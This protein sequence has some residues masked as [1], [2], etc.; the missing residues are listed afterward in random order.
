MEPTTVL[1]LLVGVGRSGSVRSAVDRSGGR[2]GEPCTLPR[3]RDR[4]VPQAPLTALAVTRL[5]TRP[6]VV[7]G[8]PACPIGV[9]RNRPGKPAKPAT[10]ASLTKPACPSCRGTACSQSASVPVVRHVSPSSVQMGV[11]DNGDEES[12]GEEMK[13]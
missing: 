11:M 2:R 3:L 5:A 13:H 1:C 8:K 12:R 4:G 9:K 10:S 7:I 6:F